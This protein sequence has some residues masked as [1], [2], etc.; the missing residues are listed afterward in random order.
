MYYQ[1]ELQGICHFQFK[2]SKQQYIFVQNLCLTLKF[3]VI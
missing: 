1:T 3:K 2:A